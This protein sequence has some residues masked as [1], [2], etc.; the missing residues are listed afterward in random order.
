MN[1]TTADEVHGRP[2]VVPVGA[3]GLG[4]AIEHG[5]V[6][7]QDTTHD[8][9]RAATSPAIDGP[10]T[11]AQ[12]TRSRTSAGTD[13]RARRGGSAG[14]RRPARARPWRSRQAAGPQH[15][16]QALAR[17]LDADRV[18]AADDDLGVLDGGLELLEQRALT[19]AGSR[20]PAGIHARRADRVD[21]LAVQ[22]GADQPDVMAVV[23][24]R[25]RERA[26]RAGSRRVPSRWPRRRRMREWSEKRSCFL[27]LVR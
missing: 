1:K 8:S 15:R 18:H 22:V 6:A 27:P 25:H 17:P 3:E 19:E 5:L 26:Q 2:H 4:E 12:P 10:M 11:A 21:D 9:R 24:E 7:P 23:G 16:G 13:R 14:R 20:V